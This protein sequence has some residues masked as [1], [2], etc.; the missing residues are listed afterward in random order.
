MKCQYGIVALMTKVTADGRV[1]EQMGRVERG[2][3]KEFG[4]CATCPRNENTRCALDSRKIYQDISALS[5]ARQ[6][7]HPTRSCQPLLLLLLLTTTTI[8]IYDEACS[9]C[10]P[11]PFRFALNLIRHRKVRPQLSAILD[12]AGF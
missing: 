7:F 8:L 2:K 10:P 3:N 11:Q 1:N 5:D 12:S 6:S 9:F 4:P